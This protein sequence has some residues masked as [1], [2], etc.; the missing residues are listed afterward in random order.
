MANEHM[1]IRLTLLV[2]REKQ[3]KAIMKSTAYRLELLRLTVSSVGE[4]VEQR[5][6]LYSNGGNKSHSGK[7][8]VVFFEQTPFSTFIDIYSREIKTYV[9]TNICIWMFIT[10]LLNSQK[11]EQPKCLPTGECCSTSTQCNTYH[12]TTNDEQYLDISQNLVVTERIP[13]QKVYA[14]WFH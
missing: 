7:Y 10:A 14:V 1:K 4:D 13:K 11:L 8:L 2:I 6:M 5:T 12:S 9:H 3:I